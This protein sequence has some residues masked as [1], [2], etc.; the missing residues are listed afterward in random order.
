MSHEKWDWIKKNI[1]YICLH[2]K[3]AFFI[4]C[5]QPTKNGGLNGWTVESEKCRQSRRYDVTSH[6][7]KRGLSAPL[8]MSFNFF[9]QGY[10][11]HIKSL[12]IQHTGENHLA[13]LIY[14]FRLPAHLQTQE[15]HP[16]PM[17][18]TNHPLCTGS[19]QE[20]L[21]FDICSH[22]GFL[23]LPRLQ[24]F[25]QPFR[26]V[27]LAT[28][29][30]RDLG[31]WHRCASIMNIEQLCVNRKKTD[32]WTRPFPFSGHHPTHPKPQIEGH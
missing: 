13:P 32:N 26:G 9:H 19:C 31:S 7:D 23:C 10:S 4:W 28:K 6:H 25:L 21:C 22:C 15:T 24:T 20:A 16:C 1:T 11:Q 14:I 2:K 8:L 5:S 18:Y 17:A 12:I 3:L 30:Q 27:E 29:H